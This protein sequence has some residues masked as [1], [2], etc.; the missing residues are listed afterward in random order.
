MA[1]ER[2]SA[3]DRLVTDQIILQGDKRVPPRDY[4]L[5]V[6][7]G[8]RTAVSVT[9][10]PIEELLGVPFGNWENRTGRVAKRVLFP[11]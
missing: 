2:E 10:W 5:V 7:W 4:C 6:K 11:L 8:H 1:Q 9:V 3:N